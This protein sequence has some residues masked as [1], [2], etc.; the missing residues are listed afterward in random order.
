MTLRWQ[1]YRHY[2]GEFAEFGGFILE[3]TGN[4]SWVVRHMLG[5]VPCRHSELE[6]VLNPGANIE[7]AKVKAEAALRELL[8]EVPDLERQ[9]AITLRLCERY[10]AMRNAAGTPEGE[11]L[12]AELDK[13]VDKYLKPLQTHSAA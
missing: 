1:K 4:G 11:A 13:S 10:R 3:A 2:E 6:P 8:T 9:Q 12:Q 7:T 5:K